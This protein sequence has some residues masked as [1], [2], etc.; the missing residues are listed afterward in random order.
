M[1]A[2]AL[3]PASTSGRGQTLHFAALYGPTLRGPMAHCKVIGIPACYLE[4]AVLSVH[5]VGDGVY[6]ALHGL[7]E[8]MVCEFFAS[9]GD[10]AFRV[11]GVGNADA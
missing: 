1:D 3:E 2:C 8:L 10:R 7:F 5:R 11:G 6:L 4:S 9:G